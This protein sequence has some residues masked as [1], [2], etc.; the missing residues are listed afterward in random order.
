MRNAGIL[1]NIETKPVG[2]A[3]L[4]YAQTSFPF[5]F[6]LVPKGAL[7]TQGSH[8]FCAPSGLCVLHVDSRPEITAFCSQGLGVSCMRQKSWVLWCFSFY[9]SPQ[10]HVREL[11]IGT[12]KPLKLE[13]PH[14]LISVSVDNGRERIATN[15]G[16]HGV[17]QKFNY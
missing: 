5:L 9:E 4:I 10:F 3:A 17:G 6:M 7:C 8:L 16:R 12:G 2:A 15:P 1:K 11:S 14:S 13:P